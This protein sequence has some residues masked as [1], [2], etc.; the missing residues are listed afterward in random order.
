MAAAGIPMLNYAWGNNIGAPEKAW[1]TGTVAVRGG[2]QAA[3]FD[4]SVMNGNATH[5]FGALS[6]EAMWDNLAYF[7]RAVMPVA[8]EV[9]VQM[10]LHP[11]D[12][13]VPVLGGI[14]QIVR[15]VEAYERILDLAP[16]PANTVNFC[17][18]CFAQMLDAEGVYDAIRA[19]GR[20]GKIGYVHFRNVR[21]N[22]DNFVEQFPDDGQ[23][24][25]AR[26]MRIYKEVGFDGYFTPDHLPHVE[27]DTAWGHRA[28]AFAIG[29][30]R[31][32]IQSL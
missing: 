1:R 24:D 10:T 3:A 11:A 20:R 12:P 14:A 8:N 17:Q 30:M 23:I 32:L 31:G 5:D 29:H 7:L 21:G 18:G 19:F 27:G 2:A 25:M 9:G 15:S 26:A 22:V 13:Q 28:R 16:G 4:R 6:D